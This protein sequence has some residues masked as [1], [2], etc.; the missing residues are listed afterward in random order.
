MA[1]DG[2]ILWQT[3]CRSNRLDGFGRICTDLDE[4]KPFQRRSK[5]FDYGTHF[6]VL[7]PTFAVSQYY[8]YLDGTF[9]DQVVRNMGEVRHWGGWLSH[10]YTKTSVPLSFDFGIHLEKVLNSNELGPFWRF[11]KVDWFSNLCSP[12]APNFA[13]TLLA[14]RNKK[15]PTALKKKLL[16]RREF[17]VIV[18][19][20]DNF[21]LTLRKNL[22]QKDSLVPKSTLPSVANRGQMILNQYEGSPDF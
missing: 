8:L 9:K 7:P 14:L 11:V 18:T 1:E 15:K 4:F 10:K 13:R 19:S 2:L 22:E 5:P 12:K 21:P 16:E 20:L 3:W 17:G 6:R